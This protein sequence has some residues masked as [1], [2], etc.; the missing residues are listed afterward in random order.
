MQALLV[1]K[2]RSPFVNRASDTCILQFLS[3]A[4][5]AKDVRHEHL[6]DAL[7]VVHDVSSTVCPGYLWTNWGL[8]FANH[9]RNT[10]DDEHQ[11]KTFATFFAQSRVFPL[12][13]Y[14]TAV[15]ILFAILIFAV[16]KETY[17]DVI[18]ILTERIRVFFKEQ[19]AELV[20]SFY[21]SVRLTTTCYGS[22]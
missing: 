18:A 8:G 6:G 14:N 9:H 22:T 21:Q 12:I 15:S 1:C 11:V 17:V 7:L 10:I 16:A 5:K 13:G 4:G 20:V 19:L 3:F 2:P